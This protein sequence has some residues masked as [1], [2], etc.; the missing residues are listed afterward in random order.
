MERFEKQVVVF[1][2]GVRN[3]VHG[4]KNEAF[5]DLLRRVAGEKRATPAQFALRPDARQAGRSFQF[6]TLTR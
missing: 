3:P 4:A 1:Q 6:V 5:V 2:G